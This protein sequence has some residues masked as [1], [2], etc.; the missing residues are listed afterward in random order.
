ARGDLASAEAVHHATIAQYRSAGDPLGA[1][2][3]VARL[4][5]HFRLAGQY[6]KALQQCEASIARFKEEGSRL[7]QGRGFLCKAWVLAALGKRREA[8]EASGQ[9]AKLGKSVG[10]KRLM[11]AALSASAAGGRAPPTPRA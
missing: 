3:A 1:A 11:A 6:G 5:E 9:A 7:G 4:A 8:D 10:S 2:L